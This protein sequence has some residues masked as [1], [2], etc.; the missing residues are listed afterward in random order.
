MII[1]A[2]Q[3]DEYHIDEA[4][5][6]TFNSFFERFVE[7]VVLLKL[8]QVATDKVFKLCSELLREF[9]EYLRKAFE[10]CNDNVAPHEII[11][12]EAEAICGK[13]DKM[14]S[15]YKR[16]K[17]IEDNQFYVHPVEKNLGIS[18]RC[19]PNAAKSIPN[20]VLRSDTYHSV[21]LIA[22][23]QSL[24]ARP[25]FSHIFFEYN[26]DRKHLCKKDVYVDYCCG[27]NASKCDILNQE[28]PAI[29][30][31]IA[32][33]AFEVCSALKTKANVHKLLAVYFRIRNLPPEYRSR[34]NNHHLLALCNSEH[35]KSE[36]FSFNSIIASVMDEIQQL[37]T[38]GIDIGKERNINGTLIHFC[39]DNLGANEAF[40][41]IRCFS[42]DFFCRMCFCTKAESEVQ[43]EEIPRKMRDQ[44][45]YMDLVDISKNG[46]YKAS[47]GVTGYCK[48]NDL[49][50][51]NIFKN[52]TIDI[53]HDLNEGICH[54]LL[55]VIFD[56]ISNNH[57][58]KNNDLI[59]LVRDFN[60][61]Y[62]F[63]KKKPSKLNLNKHNFNQNA[64]QT[65]TL[66]IHLPFILYEFKDKLADVW[67]FLVGLL[68]IMQIVYSLK[69][70]TKNIMDLSNLIK[71]YLSK[72]TNRGIRLTPKHHNLVHYPTVIRNMGP[73]IH[74]WAMRMES[75]HKEFTNHAKTLN[76][77]KNISHSLSIRHEQLASFDTYEYK[78]E[79][80]ESSFNC[81][82]KKSSEFDLYNRLNLFANH[83][84]VHKAWVLNSLSINS[85]EYR[86]G[87]M[88]LR[89]NLALE[90]EN[91]IVA[92]SCYFLICQKYKMVSFNSE[93]NSIEIKRAESDFV[94][95]DI[96][97]EE[98]KKIHQKYCLKNKMFIIADTLEIFNCFQSQTNQH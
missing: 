24:F 61:G 67:Q 17:K 37:E 72:L 43:T 50:Y 69:I 57:I 3:D 85:F 44:V 52:Y 13:L 73:P 5:H 54:T 66:L 18:W 88:L 64:T 7:N 89:N 93:L 10:H 41:F 27:I 33:D 20:H 26:N 96:L 76:N 15:M 68:R 29:M 34:L 35:L 62:L 79:I 60:Y 8:Q 21:S 46:D 74:M 53:M 22:K 6:A 82:L 80:R 47:K 75:K 91:I 30:I 97:H 71:E 38:I 94:V 28:Y 56:F 59:S 11:K 51:F 25:A 70:E 1:D 58:I 77:F 84:L 49:K 23:I 42:T 87:L 90:I 39:G 98:D 32:A 95:I 4:Y 63:S 9:S 83:F 16:K 2:Q 78:N 55:K 19:K 40:G 81:A 12:T 65:Y 14:N 31:D 86:K 36:G 45:S 48:F 92:E